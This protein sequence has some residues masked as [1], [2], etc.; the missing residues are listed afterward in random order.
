MIILSIVVP[1]FNYGRFLGQLLEQI[2]ECSYRK[3][4]EVLLIDGGSS[5]DS[6][7]I[8]SRLLLKHD[9][10]VSEK[11]DGQADAI[12]KGLSRCDGRWFMFQN[13]DDLFDS[14]GLERLMEF[15]SSEAG[16]QVA[17]YSLGET[18]EQGGNWVSRAAFTHTQVVRWQ[19]LYW[20]I[21]YPN[22]STV[23]L[24]ALAKQIGFD[25]SFRFAMDLDF[26][27]RF[28]KKF[29]PRVYVDKHV[30]GYQRHHSQTKTSQLGE[31]CAV[32]SKA[33]RRDNFSI[34]DVLIGSARAIAYHIDKRVRRFAKESH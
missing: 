6:T 14:S 22:Q 28:H 29:S 21:Y 24:S 19:Q 7:E 25:K 3:S 34:W 23:Y 27:V 30:L 4:I 18:V 33:I 2:N 9:V 8:A 26:A 10:L 11:D 15:L 13:S 5:D 16:F 12:Q 32:E 1:N 17:A 20:A 31:V